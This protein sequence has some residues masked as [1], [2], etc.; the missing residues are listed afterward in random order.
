MGHDTQVAA[1][2]F[3]AEIDRARVESKFK[4]FFWVVWG[5][6][7]HVTYYTYQAASVNWI[8]LEILHI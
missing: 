1:F 2:E 7:M 4:G 3:A 5:F 6:I 8:I